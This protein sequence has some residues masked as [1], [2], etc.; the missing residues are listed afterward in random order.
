ME[1]NVEFQR[2]LI[3]SARGEIP[4]DLVFSGCNLIN[5]FTGTVETADI[6]VYKGFIVGVGSGYHGLEE[7][8]VSG[9]TIT[10]GLIDGHLHIESSMMLPSR[11]AEAIMPHGTT[12]IIADPHEIANV[13]GLDGI[14]LMLSESRDIPLDVFFTAPSCVPATHLETSGAEIKVEDLVQIKNEARILGLAEMMNFPGVLAGATDVL[15]KIQAYKDRIIDGHAPG[16]TGHDLQAYIVAGIRSDHE[17]MELKE[18]LE[19]I[20]L[21]MMLMIREGSTAKNLDTLLPL[22]NERNEHRCCFVSDDLHPLEIA[23]R[24]HLNHMVTSAILRGLNPISAIKM[25]SWNPAQYFGLKDRGALAPGY[26]ADLVVL[27]DLSNFNIDQVYKDGQ[28][29]VDQGIFIVEQPVSQVSFPSSMKIAPISV[30]DIRIPYQD[31]KARIIEIIPGQITTRASF[32]T[33]HQRNSLVISDTKSDTLK[34]V[35]AERHKKT[36]NIAV[37]L[38]R[39]FGLRIGALATSVAH[40]SHNIIAVGVHDQDIL[41]AIREVKVMGGGMSVIKNGDL[42]AKVPLPVAGL[43]S[44]ESFPKLLSQLKNL[45]K[46]I[47]S[48]G[49]LLPEPFMCLSFLSLP[50]IPEL[51]LTDK[52]LVDVN[53]FEIVPLFLE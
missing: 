46:A 18:G 44:Q 45:K 25:A 24:G 8:D 3:R 11:L 30:D 19:K 36:G 15:D 50:V 32:E 35:V 6:A 21:G 52:G 23:E 4:A 10:P 31:R 41:Q 16:L 27:N 37:G 53:R 7:I 48:T 12:T 14:R 40:D 38:V 5:V 49:C 13:M 43:M 28:K 34:L 51:K 39:G 20:G 47:S 29:I 42:L 26:R 22:V 33:V 1:S 2:D 9:K 17:A